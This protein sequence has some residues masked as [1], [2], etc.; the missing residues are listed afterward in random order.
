MG[1][2]FGVLGG[3]RPSEPNWLSFCTATQLGTRR[4]HLTTA[5]SSEIPILEN[6]IYQNTYKGEQVSIWTERALEYMKSFKHMDP[7]GN[8]LG[9]SLSHTNLLPSETTT[10]RLFDSS[11][12]V[13]TDVRQGDFC[14]VLGDQ[15]ILALYRPDAPAISIAIMLLTKIF[16]GCCG[17]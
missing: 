11:H 6:E 5:I 1:F 16:A 12:L 4:I 8:V 15:N 9:T 14:F 13:G 7:L 3:C 2:S 17:G 10:F